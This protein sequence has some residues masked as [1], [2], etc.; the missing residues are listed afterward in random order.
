MVLF[1]ILYVDDDLSLGVAFLRSGMHLNTIILQGA[2]ACQTSTLSY[3][4]TRYS[5]LKPV[6]RLVKD[7]K[8]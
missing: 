1:V 7:T 3:C 6:V 8:R 4:V 5:L 2:T